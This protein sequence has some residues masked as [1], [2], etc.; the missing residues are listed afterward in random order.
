MP[1]R[2]LRQKR[3]CGFILTFLSQK[4]PNARKGIKTPYQF[5]GTAIEQ[6]VRNP[7]MPGRALRQR[8]GLR[9]PDASLVRN[10][11]MPGRA[12]RPMSMWPNS[13]PHL[14]RNPPMPGRALRPPSLR[15][16]QVIAPAVRNPPMPGRA[17][18]L[19]TRWQVLPLAMWS[20]TPQCPE[21]H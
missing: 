2:A 11:P 14:V 15:A 9:L 1:G 3:S 20:E 5:P 10:P 17:L 16:S 6:T 13:R 12:L 7:P 8:R 4:P 19:W 21:G 18:R